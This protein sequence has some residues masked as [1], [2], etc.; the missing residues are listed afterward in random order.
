[1]DNYHIIKD[2]N[3]WKLTKEGNLKPLL[4]SDTKQ[5]IFKQTIGFISDKTG[6]IIF[7]DENEQ[8]KEKRTSQRKNKPVKSKD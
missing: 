4:V 7:H 8:F 2:G 3:K 5:E 1:M 6:T